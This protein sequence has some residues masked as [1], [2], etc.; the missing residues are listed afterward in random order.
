VFEASLGYSVTFVEKKR[1]VKNTPEFTDVMNFL[2][3]I[4]IRV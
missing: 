4:L 3:I 2:H 1:N